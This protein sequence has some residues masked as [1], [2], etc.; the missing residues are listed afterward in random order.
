MKNF[1][2]DNAGIFNVIPKEIRQAASGIVSAAADPL[3][4]LID[5]V[6]GNVNDAIKQFPQV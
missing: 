2:S 6:Q 1:G 4:N 3:D 5:N